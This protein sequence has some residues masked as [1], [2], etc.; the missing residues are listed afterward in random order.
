[1]FPY[2]NC[3]VTD[4]GKVAMRRES[5]KPPK[6]SRSQIRYRKYLNHDSGLSFREWLRHYA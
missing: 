1:M 6:L 4:K 5:P 3:S 2:F